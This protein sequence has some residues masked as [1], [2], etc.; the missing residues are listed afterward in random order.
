MLVYEEMERNGKEAAGIIP[1][2]VWRDWEK[3]LNPIRIASD[4][5]ETPQTCLNTN[6]SSL[7]VTC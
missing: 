3:P 4:A 1:V 6:A 2:F 7:K 5:A